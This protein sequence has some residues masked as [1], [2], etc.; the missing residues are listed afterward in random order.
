MMAIGRGGPLDPGLRCLIAHHEIMNAILGESHDLSRQ[1]EA[2][3]THRI[4]ISFR[5]Q[6]SGNNITR[7]EVTSHLTQID[8]H[9]SN[10]AGQG[11]PQQRQFHRHIVSGKKCTR[12][13][14]TYSH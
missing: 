10:D 4:N 3:M 8:K 6:A 12:S 14:V 1:A 13:A 9:N 7:Y 2:D 5:F 11:P